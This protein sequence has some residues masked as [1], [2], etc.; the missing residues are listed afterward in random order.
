[1]ETVRRIFQILGVAKCGHFEGGGGSDSMLQIEPNDVRRCGIKATIILRAEP[2]NFPS[3]WAYIIRRAHCVETIAFLDGCHWYR[4]ANVHRRRRCRFL[5]YLSHGPDSASSCLGY[6]FSRFQGS[7][8]VGMSYD[9][10]A[11]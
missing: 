2:L 9:N 7:M 5:S 4:M 3:G 11:S 6:D 10:T 1:V 8:I